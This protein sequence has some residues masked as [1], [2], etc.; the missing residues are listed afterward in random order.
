MNPI[1]M[2]IIAVFMAAIVIGFFI[3]RHRYIERFLALPPGFCVEEVSNGMPGPN[4][5]LKIIADKKIEMPSETIMERGESVASWRVYRDEGGGLVFERKVTAAI[6]VLSIVVSFI[7]LVIATFIATAIL[8]IG[9]GEDEGGYKRVVGWLSVI[10]SVVVGAGAFS[11]FFAA[12][13]HIAFM[14]VSTHEAR[15]TAE[16]GIEFRLR[17]VWPLKIKQVS[18]EPEDVIATGADKDGVWAVWSCGEGEPRA[19]RAYTGDVLY[20]AL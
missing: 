1:E 10:G 14:V 17:T 20:D 19:W 12:I 8:M 15:F 11:F 5:L 4:A 3:F 6:V 2:T 13:F 7:G 16:G 9:G 18:V